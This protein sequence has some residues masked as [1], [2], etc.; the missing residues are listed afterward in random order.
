MR[1][2]K[3]LGE[4]ERQKYNSVVCDEKKTIIMEQQI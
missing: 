1:Y 2:G 3:E 4:D